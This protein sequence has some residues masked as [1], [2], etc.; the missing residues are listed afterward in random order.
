MSLYFASCKAPFGNIWV[1][2]DEKGI[3][4]IEL[5]E[6]DWVQFWGKNPDIKEG[7]ECCNEAVRQLDEYFCGKRKEFDLPLSIEG[8]AFRK[9]VWK[10]LQQ[11]PYGE[12]RSY[13]D[14][15]EMIGNPKAIRAVG[16]ANRSNQIPIIIPCHRVIGKNGNLV[17]YAG[18]NTPIKKL[19][20]E[21]EGYL[22][23]ST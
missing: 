20:L 7:S 2:A 23:L 16:Q 8:T 10:A 5:F 9:Q 4:R 22:P 3:S 1:I 18:S 14:V 12:V 13:S 15:A 17:G 11:I 6:E 19:L 21:L